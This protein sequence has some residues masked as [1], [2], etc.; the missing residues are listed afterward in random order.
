MFS[1]PTA[2]GLPV[3]RKEIWISTLP[4]MRPAY[5]QTSK[6]DLP[7]VWHIVLP[8]HQLRHHWKYRIS[9]SFHPCGNI[10]TTCF[11]RILG[12]T[13]IQCASKGPMGPKTL[14]RTIYLYI[15][16]SANTGLIDAF[17]MY[18]D[19][20]KA[21]QPQM[22]VGFVIYPHEPRGPPHYPFH[23]VQIKIVHNIFHVTFWP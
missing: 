13:A 10:L 7:M 19:H 12:C 15:Y 5:P 22:C 18:K 21:L 17:M 23:W 1:D 11:I 20:M 8:D 6:S 4:V 9:I 16:K 3:N 2:P 14:S